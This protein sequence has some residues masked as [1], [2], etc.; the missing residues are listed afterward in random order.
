MTKQFSKSWVV[1]LIKIKGS[2]RGISKQ[3]ILEQFNVVK[4][5]HLSL[6]RLIN[7]NDI[8]EIKILSDFGT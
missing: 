8:D 7:I 4:A 5:L 3:K 2:P 1:S 6:V